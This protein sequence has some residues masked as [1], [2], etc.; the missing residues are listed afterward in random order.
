MAKRKTYTIPEYIDEMEASGQLEQENVSKEELDEAYVKILDA[1]DLL[2]E[3]VIS[4][5]AKGFDNNR[6]AAKLMVSVDKI[7]AI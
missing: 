4:L 7:K 2:R 1:D 3:Q 6:I 5:R